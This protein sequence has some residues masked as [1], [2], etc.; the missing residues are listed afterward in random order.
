MSLRLALHHH[1]R[2]L[3][4]GHRDLRHGQLLVVGL[5]GGDDRS[6][7]RQHEVDAR[8]RHQIGL[9]LRDVHVQSSIEA[10]AGRQ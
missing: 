4:D 10:K 9:E 8:L 1:R 5:L 7:G 3:E 6:I 2:R